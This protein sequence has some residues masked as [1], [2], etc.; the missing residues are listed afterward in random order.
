LAG[1]EYAFFDAGDT[2]LSQMFLNIPNYTPQPIY[3]QGSQ[4][5]TRNNEIPGIHLLLRK[6][7]TPKVPI[8]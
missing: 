1:F 8:I 7:K 3:Y 2:F 4:N 6:V 5:I